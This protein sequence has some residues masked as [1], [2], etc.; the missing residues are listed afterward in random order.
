MKQLSRGHEYHATLCASKKF[1]KRHGYNIKYGMEEYV[2]RNPCGSNYSASIT[3]SDGGLRKIKLANEE[4][5]EARKL[6]MQ[7][8][9]WNMLYSTLET[10]IIIFII[11]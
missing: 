2:D 4:H 5:N 9:I 11:R 10:R 6:T 1:L 8:Q 7:F 3:N